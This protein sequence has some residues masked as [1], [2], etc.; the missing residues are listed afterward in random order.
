MRVSV[1]L[2]VVCLIAAVF[3]ACMAACSSG[4]SSSQFSTTTPHLYVVNDNNPGQILQYA[5][6]LTSS[7]TASVAMA[8]GTIYNEVGVAVDSSGNLAIGNN[9]GSLAIFN[10]PLS[11]GTIASATFKNG[12]ATSNGQLAFNSAGDL[13]AATAGP[14]VN[15]FTHPLSS[16]S[17]P[18]KVITDA[19]LSSVIGTALDSNGNLFVSSA[20]ATSSTVEVFATPYTAGATASVTVTGAAYRQIALSST[21]LFVAN[22]AGA[23]SID[24][25]NLP[26]TTGSTPAFSITGATS[27]VNGP[28]AVAVDS[29]GNLYVGN[30]NSAA[31]TVYSP[32]LSATSIPSTTLTVGSPFAIFGMTTGK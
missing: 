22:A 23:G 20:G 27:G 21:Q 11:N 8:N 25:F 14:A 15:Q 19:N 32:P 18:S 29:N 17:T 13:F 10:A 12:T 26:I 3:I 4:S 24:V 31:I 16:S 5:L 7:S 2:I 28:Q 6:P 30:L 1:R 9:A